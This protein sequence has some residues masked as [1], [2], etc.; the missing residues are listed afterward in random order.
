MNEEALNLLRALGAEKNVTLQ[1]LYRGR[2]HR[3]TYAADFARMDMKLKLYN[4]QGS[5]IYFTVNETDANGR[6]SSHIKALRAIFVDYDNGL[7]TFDDTKNWPLEPTITVSSSAGK[8]QCYW[9][10]HEPIEAHEANLNQWQLVEDH[11]VWA[12]KGD[13]AAR[14][15]ARILRLPG[16]KNHKYSPPQ[17]VNLIEWQGPRYSLLQLADAYGHVELPE[18]ATRGASATNWWSPSDIPADPIREQRFRR[19]LDRTPFPA[20]GSGQRNGFFY[21]KSCSGVIDFALDPQL[22]ASI[23]AEYSYKRH[24]AQD[25]YQYE[26]LLTLSERASTYGK[27]ARGSAYARDLTEM[28]VSA[29]LS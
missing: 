27:G 11:I 12:T 4:N 13:W 24:G 7:P 21:R 22:V 3:A 10:F 19:Y 25:A 9:V 23:L 1:T 18:S 16:Y 2:S 14:D 6:D 28:K 29:D 26:Q 17:N 5:D 8:F 20:A 15:A